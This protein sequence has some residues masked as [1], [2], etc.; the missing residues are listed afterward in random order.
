MKIEITLLFEGNYLHLRGGCHILNLIVKNGL[1]EVNALIESILNVLFIHSSP[2]RLHK[3]GE[4]VI[5]AKLYQNK[6]NATY[7]ML[8]VALK[9]RKVF[10]KMV[11]EWLPFM[12][13]FREKNEKGKVRVGPPGHENWE[14]AKAFVHYLKKLYDVTLELSASKTPTSQ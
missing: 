11:E 12:K 10:E 5:L 3:F 8:G 2:S 1:K 9:F 6:V 7:K 14:N 13:Y 4:F